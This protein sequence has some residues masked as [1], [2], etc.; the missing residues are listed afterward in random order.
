MGGSSHDLQ[1][2][3]NAIA[4]G[5]PFGLDYTLTTGVI[6]GIGR[7]ITGVAGNHIPNV[8]QTDA[9]MNPGN[10]GGPLI[11]SAGRVIG[12]NTM[13]LSPSGASAGIGFAIPIDMVRHS[14]EQLMQHGK[15][16]RPSLG[17]SVDSSGS[18]LK[19]LGIRGRTGLLVVGVSEGSGAEAAGIRPTIRDASGGVSLGDIII[20]VEEKKVRTI[21]D[22]YRALTRRKPGQMVK[23]Q[24]LRSFGVGGEEGRELARSLRKVEVEVRLARR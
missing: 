13:I 23:L 10:S 8:I 1:V 20:S 7:E 16:S 11:D 19:Y 3:Q 15:V 14:V 6:S 5:N 17:I 24:L 2:G 4:I 18:V 9:A 12:V 21:E 22:L